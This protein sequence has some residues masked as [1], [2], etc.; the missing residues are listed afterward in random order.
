MSNGE[1]KTEATDSPS[2]GNDLILA[3]LSTRLLHP[4]AADDTPPYERIAWW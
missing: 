1:T 4:V 3:Y 2:A